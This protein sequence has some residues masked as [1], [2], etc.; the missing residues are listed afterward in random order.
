M[1][2]TVYIVRKNRDSIFC[3]EYDGNIYRIV[4]VYV[5][6]V[7]T[8]HCILLRVVKSALFPTILGVSLALA[9]IGLVVAVAL[10]RARS[11]PCSQAM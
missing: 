10:V 4:C 2:R 9:H 7:Y 6:S 5:C 3:E 8:G 11:Q 1:D